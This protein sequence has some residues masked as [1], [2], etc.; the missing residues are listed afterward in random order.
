MNT[1]TQLYELI[2]RMAVDLRN[3]ERELD[4]WKEKHRKLQVTL[5]IERINMKAY[6]DPIWDYSYQ[7][8]AESVEEQEPSMDIPELAHEL[9][10][11]PVRMTNEQ[12]SNEDPEQT[13]TPWTHWTVV[14][15]PDPMTP[16]PLV[17]QSNIYD[18]REVKWW[19]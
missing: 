18:G 6:T 1:E 5:E 17:R 11:R 15:N 2:G 13:W 4:E 8:I 16:P 10:T 7:P 3:K 14:E 19:V 12:N 9:S